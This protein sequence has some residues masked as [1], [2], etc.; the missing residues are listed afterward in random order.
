[1]YSYSSLDNY[2][3]VIGEMGKVKCCVCPK[4]IQSN[5]KRDRVGTPSLW[6]TFQLYVSKWGMTAEDFDKENDVLCKK[7]Y[8]EVIIY[9]LIYNC[10]YLL[11]LKSIT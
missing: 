7:H 5:Q 8:A 9:E 10:I 6:S 11:L 2:T 1:L 3:V 4:V